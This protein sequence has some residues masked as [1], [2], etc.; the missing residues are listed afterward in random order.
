[1]AVL[2]PYSSKFTNVLDEVQSK[3]AAGE[4]GS[5]NERKDFIKSKGLD[6]D[7]FKKTAIEYDKL[8]E[9]DPDELRR[10]GFGLGRVAGRFAGSLG[11][12]IANISGAVAP[13]FTKKVGEKYRDI[14]PESIQKDL[15]ATFKPTDTGF[16][17]IGEIGGFIA[18]GGAGIKLLGAVAKGAKLKKLDTAT[19]AGKIGKAAKIGTGFAIGTTAIEKPEDNFVNFL[20]DY[21][22]ED[23]SDE[24]GKK[25]GTFG[26]ILER[27]KV[28]PNDSVAQKYARAFANN[29]LVEGGF[30][31]AFPIVGG[32]L[33][34]GANTEVAKFLT[35]G[36][37]EASAYVGESVPLKGIKEKIKR[38][39]TSRMGLN[40]KALSLLV[41]REGATKA[42]ITR[43]EELSIALKQT[44]KKEGLKTTDDNLKGLNDALGGDL[45][46]LES[47]RIQFPE[48]AKVLEKMRGEIKTLSK[49]VGENIAGGGLKTTIGRN[50]DTY[51]NRTYRIFDDP[52]YSLKNIPEKDRENAIRYFRETL[53]I[54]EKD[55]PQVLKA[56]TDGM[57]KGEFNSF[58]KGVGPRTSQILKQRKDI[59]VEIRNLWGEVKDPF[60]NYVNS[61][62][63]LAN[64]KSEY[65][66]RK[67]IAEEALKQG[68]AVATRDPLKGVGRGQVGKTPEGEDVAFQQVERL[69]LGGVRNNIDDPL[70]G[71]FLNDAWK[72]GI[73]EGTE[74]FIGEGS[75]LKSWMKI[76]ATSQAMKTVFSIPTHGRN[77]LG[78]LFIMTAN[79][80]VNP[81]QFG[82]AFKDTSR[83]LLNINTK[84]GR[85]RL[86]RYQELG[87]VDSA[88][89][90]RQLRKSAQEGF[91]LG[92]NGFAQKTA[93]GRGVKKGVEKTTQL[94]E[95]EDNL[96]KIANFEN[97]LKNY[98]KAFPDMPKEQLERFVAQRTRDMM[99]NY[100][101][102]PKA[103]K[104]LRAMPVGNF[105]AFPAEMVR[106]SYNLAKYAWKDISGRTAKELGIT[107]P[108]A[109]KQL[110]NIGYKRLA[111]M[112]VAAIAGDAAVDQS[113][114]IFGISDEQEAMFQK[115]LA[116]WEQGTNKIFLSPLQ[117]NKKGDIEVEYMNLG[118]ID[119]YAYIKNP[120]KMVINAAINNQDYN[121]TELNDMYTKAIT[122]VIAPFTNPSMALA[123]ALEAYRGK[124]AVAD[125]SALA[126]ISRVLLSTFTPGTVDFFVRRQKFLESREARGEGQEV[127]QY[128]FGINPGEVDFPAFFGIKRQKANLSDSFSF[129]TNK[130]IGDMRRAKSRF[131]NKIRD[132]SVTNPDEIY[133]AYKESQQNK[134]KHAQRLRGLVKAYRTLGMD[135]ADMYTSLTKDGLLEGREDEF[136]DIIFAD[137]NIFMADEIPEQSILL[138]EVETG[139]KIPY[140]RIY[141]LYSNLTGKEID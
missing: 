131:T 63:K 62:T 137:Q 106:N 127:N 59:P 28:N 138:G 22:N 18:G 115:T 99:P 19:R 93:A 54:D 107:D 110:R 75:W 67:E 21:V 71:L 73:E 64:L 129:A 128:G 114:E 80:T 8:M 100:N 37:K 15:Q 113:K 70:E 94:Y 5:L 79:G 60:V 121:E 45:G 66:F 117:R 85:E 65:K 55:I 112:S 53:K 72:K 4:L 40:D 1:M 132:Y 16:G 130:P 58:L 57:K 97:L 87:V 76:K 74:V 119:P 122:D 103:I 49:D 20:A 29:L 104:S 38:Y 3:I 23:V 32:L 46:A 24:Q 101:L 108:E 88:I 78:N 91:N 125:E 26:S 43:A 17:T 42:A 95:A 56:Y 51:L 25:I 6:P 36:V 135:E 120:V 81:S 27:L 126:P 136:K 134:L 44:A 92:P 11:E 123:S 140:N 82:K 48:T 7:E 77:I 34:A 61:F 30:A 118:P 116:P 10:P 47:I 109:I 2:S 14:V 33:K 141:E 98:R 52:N 12:G 90:A 124:G 139:K 31:A 9:E 41:E 83:R 102:V 50:L 35:K 89:D 111:G 105:V 96:F 133:D 69:G 13:E 84:E 68:D 39:G 86:A